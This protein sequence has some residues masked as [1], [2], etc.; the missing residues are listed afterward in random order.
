MATSL[1]EGSAVP[2]TESILQR[3]AEEETNE[4]ILFVHTILE[5]WKK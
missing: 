5:R 4:V 3:A 1:P 2:E